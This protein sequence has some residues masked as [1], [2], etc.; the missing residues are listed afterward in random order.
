MLHR[1]AMIIHARKRAK[2]RFGIVLTENNKY[3]ILEK[4]KNQDTIA[5]KNT[6]NAI[7]HLMIFQ[8]RLIVVVKNKQFKEIVTF[9]RFQGIK[10]F[11]P[12]CDFECEI[13]IENFH[14]FKG[15]S[16]GSRSVRTH[17]C[18]DITSFN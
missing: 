6:N 1:Q 10:K 7:E 11:C 9:V 15:L 18:S 5:L 8:G 17:P 3:E 2:E 4:I 16:I 13:T 14:I 12:R